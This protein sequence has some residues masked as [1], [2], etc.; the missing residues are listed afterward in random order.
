MAQKIQVIL[1]DDL[2]GG[3]ADETVKFALDG[4]SYEIDVSTVN[5][6]ALRAALGPYVLAGRRTGGRVSTR[7]S[8]AAR[9]VRDRV[10]LSL[11]RAWARDNGYEVSDRGRMSGEI[12]AAYEAAT[13]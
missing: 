2:D 5:A 1:T 11:V 3:E 7:P 12:R 13:A 6:D 8:G 4:V 10:D 9:P